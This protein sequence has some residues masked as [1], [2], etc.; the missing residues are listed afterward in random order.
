MR[1]SKLAKENV[2]AADRAELMPVDGG[3][4]MVKL[5]RG[6]R[7]ALMH[8]ADIAPAVYQSAS[9][10]ARALRRLRPDLPL[11]SFA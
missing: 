5:W 9:H 11:T 2:M 4:V 8:G 6:E 10:A 3:G 1:M 7:T